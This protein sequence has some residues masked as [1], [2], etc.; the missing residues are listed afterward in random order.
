MFPRPP[1]IM[2]NTVITYSTLLSG[3]TKIS[4]QMYCP[5]SEPSPCPRK[6]SP[7]YVYCYITRSTETVESSSGPY[8]KPGRR[9][10]GNR[11]YSV[12]L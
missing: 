12:L 11:R 1:Q 4:S 8:I 9:S 3:F 5:V 2:V 6:P 10:S 7:L